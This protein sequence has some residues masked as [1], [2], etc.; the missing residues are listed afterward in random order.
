MKS[1]WPI[2]PPAPPTEKSASGSVDTSIHLLIIVE[3]KFKFGF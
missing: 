3:H 2:L 1:K